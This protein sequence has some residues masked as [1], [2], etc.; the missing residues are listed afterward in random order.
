LAR[1]TARSLSE[2]LQQP[3]NVE[4][5]PSND[6]VQAALDVLKAPADG[7]TLLFATS[8]TLGIGP[9]LTNPP[10]FNVVLDF[11]PDF[12]PVSL[13]ATI[14]Y[15]LV[16]APSLGLKDAK[17]AVAAMKA[18]PGTMRYASPGRTDPAHLLMLAFAGRAGVKLQE[19]AFK[20]A[21]EAQAALLIGKADFVF[22]D[23]ATALPLVEQGRLVV[24]GTAAGRPFPFKSEILPLAS[25]APGL[26]S[27]VWLGIVARTG[28]PK[29]VV[30]QLSVEMREMEATESYREAVRKLTM[31]SNPAQKAEH[32]GAVIAADRPVW[33]DL[34]KQA[35]TVAP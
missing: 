2:R 18:K 25:V 11:T 22:V 6:L 13:L 24:L 21:K 26:D 8:R 14:D 12:T 16:A 9:A 27:R 31:E 33:A 4:N 34:V 1:L 20:D 15:L 23:A 3:V 17:A 28:T 29:T 30:R 10:P 32:F 7:Y 35:G 19:V 5:R